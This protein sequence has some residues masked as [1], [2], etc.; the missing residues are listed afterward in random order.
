MRPRD[1]WN[2]AGAEFVEAGDAI[3]M[4]PLVGQAAELP[5]SL[6]LFLVAVIHPR[7]QFRSLGLGVARTKVKEPFVRPLRFHQPFVSLVS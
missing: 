1:W 6:L 5:Q 2:V 3:R 7:A 4:L